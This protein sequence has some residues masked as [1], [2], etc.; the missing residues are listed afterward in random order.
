MRGL[1]MPSGRDAVTLG[2][3]WA[4][5]GLALESRQLTLLFFGRTGGS[6]TEKTCS[7]SCSSRNSL[8]GQTEAQTD[9]YCCPL[10]AWQGFCS[11]LILSWQQVKSRFRGSQPRSAAGMGVWG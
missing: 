10:S 6:D 3:H 2:R 5:Q 8:L 4:P 7:Q 11:L 1:E 9:R